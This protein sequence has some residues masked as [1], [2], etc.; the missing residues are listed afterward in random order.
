MSRAKTNNRQNAELLAIE[1]GKPVRKQPLPWELP[2][3]HWMGEEEARLT[4]RVLQAGSP[5]RF[6]GLKP[7]HMTDKLEELFRKRINRRYA[8]GVNSGTA[9]LSISLGALGIGPGDEV[10]LPGYF[11]VSC[12][13]AIVRL[14]AIPKLVDI[15]DTFCM[16]PEDLR[17]KITPHSRAVLFVHMSGCTGHIDQVTAI[18]REKGLK[19][20]EDVAQANGATFKGKPLGSFGDLA[21]FSFQ[22]NK[23][24]SSGEGGLIVCD[25]EHLYKRCFAIHD[26]GYARN[27]AGRLDPTDERYQLWGMGCRMSEV[28]AAVALAQARKLD[29]IVRAMRTSKWAIRR[30]LKK[31][32]GLQFRRILDPAGDSGPFLITI[33]PSA[34][35][36]RRFTDALRAEGIR[37]VPGSTACLYM[38]E[39]GL[40][41][42]FNVPSLTHRRSLSS[43]GW[44]WTH[45]ANAFAA[46]Y[47]YDRGTLPMCDDMARRGALLTIASC[48]TAKDRQE[49]VQAFR[50]V[51]AKML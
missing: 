42:H 20:V 10:L 37:G 40:H 49:I 46:E 43:D 47:R 41:W 13:S 17:Q 15:D 18:C 7:Q 1:G 22:L 25:D 51:A 11:W 21:I 35:I 3:A 19:L 31:I 50:K 4:D 39:W 34:D 36:A 32:P 33:Y 30:E 38:E 24:M 26:L 28:T 23:N 27:A 45:P 9:A 2:G 8:L 14:G 44:P 6:Y 5:F 29:R 12:V 16:S 48:L